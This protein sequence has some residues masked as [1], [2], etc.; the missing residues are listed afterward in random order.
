[1]GWSFECRI[2]WLD[3]DMPRWIEANCGI[4]KR[5]GGSAAAIRYRE[6]GRHH[7]PQS[8]ETDLRH[9]N[10]LLEARVSDQ[11][12]E[13]TVA[14]DELRTTAERNELVEGELTCFP[15]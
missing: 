12:W 8:G 3:D 4:I 1:M 15:C 7:H 5:T 14:I 6:C 11:A 13:L 2:L 9:A 10:E